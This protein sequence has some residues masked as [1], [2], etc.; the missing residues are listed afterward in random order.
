MATALVS[1]L[2]GR[3]VRRDVAMT[4]ELT[5]RGKV[6]PIGGLPE[7]AV[8]AQRAGCRHIIVPLGNE[9]DYRELSRDVRKG[10][11]WEL[12]QRMDEVLDI[13]LLPGEGRPKRPDK[14]A[15][16]DQPPAAH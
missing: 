3:K 4:G 1:I 12:V 7:K 15:G 16:L 9:K 13:A 14:P 11:K 6:L 5:L 8:A 10:L 2:T